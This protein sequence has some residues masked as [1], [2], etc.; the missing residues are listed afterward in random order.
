MRQSTAD[1]CSL[2]SWL[3]LSSLGVASGMRREEKPAGAS[4][5]VFEVRSGARLTH[6]LS[7]TTID[8]I[9]MLR[10]KTGYPNRSPP[11]HG[12]LGGCSPPVT[13]EGDDGAW[14]SAQGRAQRTTRTAL[15]S[16]PRLDL[17]VPQ[18]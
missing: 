10:S 18:S 6:R 5:A 14:C 2:P 13:R 16:A 11:S 4:L 17:Q 12:H 1:L 15:S 7:G 8:E 3:E 9:V